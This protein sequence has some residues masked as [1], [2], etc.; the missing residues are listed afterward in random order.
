MLPLI[1][2]PCS[3]IN[4][5]RADTPWQGIKT[6]YV[7]AVRM[8][9]GTPVLIPLL[10]DKANLETIW[11]RL[12]GLLLPGGGD[13]SPE[14]YGEEVKTELL[15]LDPLRDQIELWMARR[16]LSDD[17]PLLAICRGMQV[18][19]VAAG[20][21]LYQDIASEIPIARK[22]NC[23]YP[24]HKSDY[25]AH[26][27]QPQ[28]DSLLARVIRGED[29]SYPPPTLHVNSRHHQALKEIGEDLVVVARSPDG[30]IEAVESPIHRF[31]LGVQWHPEDLL[32]HDHIMRHLFESLVQAASVKRDKK[33]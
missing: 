10:D 20:G 1:G 8:A 30:I 5:S 2:I 7:N 25:L 13:I 31:I 6:A 9:K 22:H 28:I 3:S 29:I 32:Q 11:E 33:Y 14:F 27:V 4:Y 19:N 24:E 23:N 21:N 12:D 16:A 18:L 26:V 15:A 17:M